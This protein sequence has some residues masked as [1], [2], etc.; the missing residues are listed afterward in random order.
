MKLSVTTSVTSSKIKIAVFSKNARSFGV[1]L[2]ALGVWTSAHASVL[3]RAQHDEREPVRGAI[4]TPNKANLAVDTLILPQHVITDSGAVINRRFSETRFGS[5]GGWIWA[6]NVL[7]SN[8]DGVYKRT[9]RSGWQAFAVC[10]DLF[11]GSKFIVGAIHCE[12]GSLLR[13][14]GAQ[15]T[16]RID[17]PPG[18]RIRDIP[19]ET[20]VLLQRD[21]DGSYASGVIENGLIRPSLLPSVPANSLT[22][23]LGPLTPSLFDPSVVAVYQT[24]SGYR[25]VVLSGTAQV[26]YAL[27]IAA[28]PLAN[29]QCL[30]PKA[31]PPAV[32]PFF[33]SIERQAQQKWLRVY[34]IGGA[35]TLLREEQLAETDELL[36]SNTNSAFLV[37]HRADGD[38]IERILVNAPSPGTTVIHPQAGSAQLFVVG[39]TAIAQFSDQSIRLYDANQ[40]T[41]GNPLAGARVF[42]YWIGSDSAFGSPLQEV[43][44][45]ID[46]D[47]DAVQIVVR[48]RD[49]VSGS[50]IE[51]QVW[52]TEFVQRFDKISPSPQLLKTPTPGAVVFSISALETQATGVVRSTRLLVPSG[53]IDTLQ[54][55]RDQAGAVAK[56]SSVAVAGQSIYGQSMP[57]A[58]GSATLYRWSVSGQFLAQSTIASAAMYGQANGHILLSDFSGTARQMRMHDGSSE[59]WRKDLLNCATLPLDNFPALDCPQN[60][61]TVVLSNIIK[62]D[63]N[64][65]NVVWARTVTPLD[66]SESW[67]AASAWLRQ[68]ELVL[69]SWTNGAYQIGVAQRPGRFSA[70]RISADTGALLSVGP[71]LSAEV[72][73]INFE[74]RDRYPFNDDWLRFSASN[75]LF[76]PGLRRRFAIRVGQ[77]GELSSNLLGLSESSGFNFSENYLYSSTNDGPRWYATD[78]ILFEYQSVARSFP[79]PAIT[80]PLTLH[81]EERLGG[82][83]PSE[84]AVPIRISVRNPNTSTA[85]GARLYTDTMDCAAVDADQLSILIDVPANSTLTFDCTA[86]ALPAGSFRPIKVFVRQPMNFSGVQKTTTESLFIAL[87][88]PFQN[89]FED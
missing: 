27:P 62:L 69:L 55:L 75:P 21:S 24:A 37:K 44:T 78:G 17:V 41:L 2:L 67:R 59:L 89:G 54:T 82:S 32:E 33:F 31:F 71:S 51:T 70:A 16:A 38:L 35:I 28:Q 86:R 45:R 22:R 42:P 20:L 49:H 66:V 13:Y 61:G 76:E 72:Q 56:L 50:V 26:N 19:S 83:P 7:S 53:A 12:S 47:T 48:S 29:Q 85:Q 23:R 79:G 15:V 64:N 30:M 3:W 80:Q 65:G 5:S 46:G 81:V 57:D 87:P 68:N 74:A 39:K 34:A 1:V 18:F 11:E 73:S 52:N 4:E 25:S 58:A 40:N 9:Q 84:T 6:Q 10:L 8:I 63:A 43:F 14:R 77:T 36:C 60:V 88:R